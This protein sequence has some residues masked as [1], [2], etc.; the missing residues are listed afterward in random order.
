M[1]DT[2]KAQEWAEANRK[3]IESSNEFV[4][5]MGSPWLPSGSLRT[6]RRST[7]GINT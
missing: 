1:T 5:K 6:R 3:T 7:A 4:E 2:K